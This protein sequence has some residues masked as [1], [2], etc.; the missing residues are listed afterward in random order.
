MFS[1]KICG[2][3][4]AI[5][6][7][8]LVMVQPDRASAQNVDGVTQTR[9]EESGL[10]ARSLPERL[11]A[12]EDKRRALIIFAP[13][14]G[15][16]RFGR[17]RLIAQRHVVDFVEHRIVVIEAAAKAGVEDRLGLREVRRR[18]DVDAEDFAVVLLDLSGE[19]LLR[20][21]EPVPAGRL[22]ESLPAAE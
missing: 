19:V 15:D 14:R 9:D 4:L 7:A 18:F 22:I 20:S 8:S 2:A 13:N 3:V 1:R 11:E 21:D 5:L 10:Q 6:A 17:Q 12:L 16:A